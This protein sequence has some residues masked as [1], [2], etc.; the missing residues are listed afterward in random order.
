MRRT[1]SILCFIA[2]LAVAAPADA[3]LRTPNAAQES[4]VRLYDQG[5]TGFSLNRFFTPEHFRMSHSLEMTASSFGGGSSLAMYTNTMNWQFNEKLAARVD[6]SMAYSPLSG[7]AGTSV[8]GHSNGQIFLRN[9]EIAYRPSEN[10]SIHLSIQQS[11]Y[12]RFMQPYGYGSAGFGGARYDRFDLH[13]GATG[14]F[15]RDGFD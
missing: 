1:A 14:L 10:T 2:L 9:A 5:M 3:Q 15:W 7:Q 8:T 11:P 13:S 6:V 12:G 4:T